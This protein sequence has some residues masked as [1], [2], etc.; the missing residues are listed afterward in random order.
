MGLGQR[1]RVLRA[2]G[3][4]AAAAAP[5]SPPRRPTSWAAPGS[6]TRP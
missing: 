3:G 1:T 6:G 2:P 5:P 4:L